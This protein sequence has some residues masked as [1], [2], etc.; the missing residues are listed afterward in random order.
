MQFWIEEY[1]VRVAFIICHFE[2]IA[3]VNDGLPV[4]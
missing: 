4:A 3:T 1:D 2:S